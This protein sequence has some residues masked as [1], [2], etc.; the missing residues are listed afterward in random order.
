VAIAVL[1]RPGG[2]DGPREPVPGAAPAPP[3]LAIGLAE[4]NPHLIRPGPVPEGFG[5]W[6]DRAAALRPRVFRLLVDWSQV[7]PSPAAPPDW[8]APRDG[9]LRG[10]APCGEYAGVRDLLAAL[11]ERQ[12]A[13]GGWEVVA[14]PYGA[15]AWALEPAAGCP[16]GG[17]IRPAAYA[18]FLRSLAAVAREAGVA[19]RRWSPWNEPNH[20][21][22]LAPQRGAC[23]PDAPAL[24]PAAYAEL[25]RTARRALGR[26]ARLVIG[27]VAGYDRPRDEAVGAAE[28]AAALP[29]DVA[30]AA[31]VWGQHAYVGR[32]SGRLAADREAGGHRRLLRAVRTALDAHRCPEPHRIWITETGAAPERA[33]GEDPCAAMDRALRAWA[34]D[35]RVD[36][37][38]QYT[39]REDTAFR[40]GLADAGLTTELP[41]YAAWRAWGARDPGGPPP[42]PPCGPA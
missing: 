32:G 36:V 2:G 12:A 10:L 34:A 20:P 27:E 14:S 6:R 39:F 31:T 19:V 16:S 22:F 30:C 29:R 17:T 28:F 23:A 13:D 15:P 33:G 42:D 1:L 8:S 21:T 9:C 4:Q 18:A 24:S 38:V 11:A 3:G 40:V 26:G 41:S 5:A 37:A 7:Q 25:V 35:P